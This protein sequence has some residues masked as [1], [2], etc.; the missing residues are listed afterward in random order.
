MDGIGQFRGVVDEDSMTWWP[1]KE[2]L[3]G[4]RLFKE[5]GERF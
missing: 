1:T 4:E 2:A 5:Y 3:M